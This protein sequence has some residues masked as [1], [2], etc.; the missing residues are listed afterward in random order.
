M[1][2]K[3]ISKAPFMTSWPSLTEAC[4]CILSILPNALCTVF[5]KLALSGVIVTSV[6]SRFDTCGSIEK[7]KLLVEEI[8]TIG[9]PE[10]ALS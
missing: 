9:S 10:S 3:L 6:I 7:E 4:T 2:S 8:K 1:L 5:V